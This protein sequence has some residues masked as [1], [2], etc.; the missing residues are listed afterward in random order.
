MKKQNSLFLQMTLYIENPKESTRSLIGLING[1]SKVAGYKI[2]MQ[3]S[4][5]FLAM[6]NSKRKLRKQVYHTIPSK[7]SKTPRIHL[8]SE[9]KD[10]YTENY[11]TML[12]KIK[13]T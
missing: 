13:E 3:K 9:M 12:G 7:R 4:V 5:M 6:N 1:F 11:K 8:I 10:L 2:N